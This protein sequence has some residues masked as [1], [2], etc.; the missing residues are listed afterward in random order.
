MWP[1]TET[2]LLLPA[3]V[4][5]KEAVGCLQSMPIVMERQYCELLIAWF[6]NTHSHELF[7]ES[8]AGAHHSFLPRTWQAHYEHAYLRTLKRRFL[9]LCGCVRLEGT[10]HDTTCLQDQGR[11]EQA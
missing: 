1:G 7:A 5:K 10:A 11:P 9:A 8:M 2:W 4:P 3:G 6:L